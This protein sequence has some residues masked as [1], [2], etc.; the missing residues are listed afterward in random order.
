M[1][2]GPETRPEWLILGMRSIYDPEA[3]P[4][5]TTYELRF[6]DETFWARTDNGALA[7]GRGEAPEPDAV[8]TSDVETIAK[9]IR[10]LLTPAAA[11]RS[12]AV[13]LDGQRAAFDRFP[14]LFKF[15]APAGT[16]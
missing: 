12:G 10:G 9:L 3:H 13:R 6:G 1:R 14:S 4:D 2:L 8:L 11:L 16:S 15:P 7:V 5:S